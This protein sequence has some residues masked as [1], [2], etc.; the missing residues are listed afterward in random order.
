MHIIWMLLIGLVAGALAKLI[1]PGKDPGGVIVTMLIGVAGAL[2][3]GFVGRALGFYEMGDSAGLIAAVIGSLALL[4]AY[5]LFLHFRGSTTE[6]FGHE[7]GHMIRR[8]LGLAEQQGGQPVG[9]RDGG[10]PRPA[11]EGRREPRGELLTRD[12]ELVTGRHPQR[13]RDRAHEV[14]ERVAARLRGGGDDL[15]VAAGK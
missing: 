12:A 5:R 4:G 1:M 15:R 6:G 2:L 11:A 3:A 14:I 7:R 13:V 10:G 8:V 9:L